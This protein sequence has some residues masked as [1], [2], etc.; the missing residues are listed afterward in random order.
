MFIV[1]TWE[2]LSLYFPRRKQS[3]WIF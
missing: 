3:Y 2:I 1:D